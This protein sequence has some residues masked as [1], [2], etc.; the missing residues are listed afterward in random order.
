MKKWSFKKNNFIT[1]ALSISVERQLPSLDDDTIL[2]F[3]ENNV[4][5]SLILIS[6][7]R[8][9]FP[10]PTPTYVIHAVVAVAEKEKKR[11]RKREGGYYPIPRFI[12]GTPRAPTRWHIYSR[13]G[14]SYMRA[15]RHTSTGKRNVAMET[16]MATLNQY[17]RRDVGSF[18]RPAGRP[19]GWSVGR[20]VG[21][22][23]GWSVGDADEKPT[24]SYRPRARAL[25]RTAIVVFPLPTSFSLSSSCSPP[26]P[27]CSARA[28]CHSSLPRGRDSR[29]HSR[30]SLAESPFATTRMTNRSRYVLHL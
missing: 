8:D 17:T 27:C 24:W 9:P 3:V 19:A 15:A 2:R 14:V 13:K 1:C 11:S 22:S 16:T 20:S 30:V 26:L 21:R 23:V 18:V 10:S 6:S 12:V 29:F 25:F 5:I 4:C 28:I 7:A